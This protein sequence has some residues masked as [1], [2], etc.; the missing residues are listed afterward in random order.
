LVGGDFA[1]ERDAR[2]VELGRAREREN[3]VIPFAVGTLWPASQKVLQL[4]LL[5]L[6]MHS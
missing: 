5:L 4:S 6:H 1:E 2:E 3:V